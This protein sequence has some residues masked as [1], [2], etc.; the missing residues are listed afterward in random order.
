MTSRIVV[1]NPVDTTLL[2]TYTITYA[3]SDSSGNAATPVTRTVNVQPQAAA[4]EGGGGAVG[5]AWLLSLLGVAL[6]RRAALSR[7]G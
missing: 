1:T 4:E 6:M 3:V 7:R 2:G 5:F